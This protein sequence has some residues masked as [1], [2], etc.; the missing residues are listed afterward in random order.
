MVA[1]VDLESLSSTCREEMED[2]RMCSPYSPQINCFVYGQ[3]LGGLRF[4][5]VLPPSGTTYR[6]ELKGR[7]QLVFFLPTDCGCSIEIIMNA[8]S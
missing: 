4:S 1:E 8:G 7:D 5:F 2:P 6:M 3:H